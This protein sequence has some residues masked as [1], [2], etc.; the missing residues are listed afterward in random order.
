MNRVSVRALLD[1]QRRRAGERDRRDRFVQHVPE[2]GDARRGAAVHHHAH[3]T[4]CQPFGLERFIRPCLR[5]ADADVAIK[6]VQRRRTESV[7]RGAAND[8]ATLA[9]A[10]DADARG[11]NDPEDFENP[12][13][14]IRVPDV[15]VC[16]ERYRQA[17]GRQVSCTNARSEAL[18]AT[19]FDGRQRLALRVRV[20]IDVPSM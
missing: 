17:L 20:S 18:R 3:V 11:L 16:A 13:A 4:T 1:D 5:I 7:I 8:D 6:L 14:R 15:T 10:Y 9:D 19:D 12:S 2:A